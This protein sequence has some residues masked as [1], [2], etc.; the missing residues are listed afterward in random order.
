VRKYDASGNE[1][2]TNQFGTSSFDAL[3]SLQG[4]AAQGSA[5][6]VGG[7]TFGTFPGGPTGSGQDFF[8]AKI[9]A[10]EMSRR[11]APFKVE[12]IE[13]LALIDRLPTHHDSPPPL[14]ASTKRNHDS[15]IITSD[16]FNSI[17]PKLPF[18]G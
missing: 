13:Q 18:H 5:V 15:P 1:L 7:L 16:F 4:I 14:K 6:F 12:E 2:W 9:D 10:Q 8:L 17:D 11:N 3:L